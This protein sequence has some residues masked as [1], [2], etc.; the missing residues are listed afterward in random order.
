MSKLKIL[1]FAVLQ[2]FITSSIYSQE[3]IEGVVLENVTNNPLADTHVYIEN[4]SLGTITNADG[5]FKL[6]I[7]NK[8]HNEKIVFS[9]L[10]FEVRKLEVTHLLKQNDISITLKSS[11][12]V[13]DEVLVYST[14]SEIDGLTIVQRAFENYNQ[15]FPDKPF[16]SKG[17]IRHTE[18]TET[19]YKWMTEVAFEMYDPGQKKKIA[20][21]VVESRKS[22]DSRELDTI[23]R[24]TAYQRDITNY[25]FRKRN[26][27]AKNYKENFDKKFIIT[28]FAYYDNHF[29]GGYNKKI[30]LLE[31]ILKDNKIRNY[32]Q[33]NAIFTEEN[34]E[35]IKFETD[36]IL[37]FGEEKVFKVKFLITYTDYPQLGVGWLFIRAKDYAIKE[38]DYSLILGKNHHY[39][40]ATG[41]KVRYS[42]NYKFKEFNKKMYPIYASY[43]SFKINNSLNAL[44]ERGR[45]DGTYSHDEILFSEIITNE[46]DVK[47]ASETIE[48]WDDNMFSQRS[49]NASFWKNYNILLVSKEQQ[50][51]ISDLENKI[52]LKKQ[53]EQE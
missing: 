2:F 24:L 31:K 52:S 49:Y 40:K 50:K 29:T 3:T 34:L 8:Y 5:F 11:N 45:F 43:K 6:V 13:L 32:N 39:R 28:A 44:K 4:K 14:N 27:K 53:F 30:G 36:T 10:G 25:G 46:E 20:I 17:F 18:R 51:L 37:G 47:R 16:F 48:T 1:C 23:S 7:P 42:T 12:E 41:L 21:N 22:L 35:K 38:I 15:N 19:E 26:K 33:K 9:L